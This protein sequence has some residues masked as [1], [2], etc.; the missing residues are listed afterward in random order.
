MSDVSAILFDAQELEDALQ[1]S[2][3][4][5]QNIVSRLVGLGRLEGVLAALN[6]DTY[7]L[8]TR[9]VEQR[10][11]PT[12]EQFISSTHSILV[13]SFAA[14]LPDAIPASKGEL[15]QRLNEC[16]KAVVLARAV[17]S[18][19]AAT[20][21]A[22]TPNRVST[23]H[24]KP[25]S[26]LGCPVPSTPRELATLEAE[27]LRDQGDVLKYFL[28]VLR[29]PAREDVIARQ[30]EL[31]ELE[32]AAAHAPRSST[33]DNAAMA[34]VV[35]SPTALVLT[36]RAVSETG[37]APRP[38][39]IPKAAL[40]VENVE[41]FGEWEVFC[42]DHANKEL[43]KL[44]KESKDVFLM[45]L[46]KIRCRA[47]SQ[48][49]G[50]ANNI[51]KPVEFFPEVREE[52][53]ELDEPTT[54]KDLDD[55]DYETI[56]SMHRQVQFSKALFN[57]FLVGH[58]LQ[59][60]Y[61]PSA[62]EAEII[63]HPSSC[64]IIGRSGTGKTLTMMYKII[65]VERGW[66]TASWY[67]PR[68]RQLFVT[69]SGMLSRQVQRTVG[70]ILESF[71][72]ADMTQQEL[73]DIW[74]RKAE[75]AEHCRPLPRKW[76]EL[77]DDHFP[78]MI[79]F[80]K[81][82]ELLEADFTEA[83]LLKVRT[84]E[85]EDEDL[86]ETSFISA[87]R[88][89]KT[90]WDHLPK[91]A[92]KG[93]DPASV[94]GEIMGVIKGSEGTVN[95]AHGYLDREAYLKLGERS[96]PTFAALRDKVYDIF[97]RYLSL[98][99]RR[100]ERDDADRTHDLLSLLKV[101]GL[102]GKPV[103]FLFN[104]EAQ[105]NLIIDMLLLR[106]LCN[107]PNGLCW[108]GDT[109]Q[110]I[111]LGSSFKFSELTS[112]MYSIE[113][114]NLKPSYW[115]SYAPPR[116]FHL[117]VNYRS[118]AGIINCAQMIVDILTT[119]WSDSIDR[120]DP[121]RGWRKGPKPKFVRRS[122]FRELFQFTNK[123]H[124]NVRSEFSSGQCIIV[125][126]D[127]SRKELFSRGTPGG[128]VMTVY[129]S[130]G[131][132][133]NDV[134]LWHFFESSEPSKRD[135]EC[136]CEEFQ[137]TPLPLHKTT[138]QYRNL[139][140]LYVAITRARNRLWIIEA[141]DSD[142]ADPMLTL[143]TAEDAV[144]VTEASIPVDV[145]VEPDTEGWAAQGR[146]Q[147][148][149][150]NFDQAKY[151]FGR[152]GPGFERESKIAQAYIDREVAITEEEFRAAAS[153]FERCAMSSEGMPDHRELAL[154]AA[155][156][157]TRA[158]A[159]TE[160]A[161]L[162]HSVCEY[163]KCT[164]QYIRATMME[165]ARQVV[166]E[167]K[168]DVD[169]LV[170]KRVCVYFLD[171]S[172]YEPI[173]ELF[174][175]DE[176]SLT[177]FMR[178]HNLLPQLA[179]YFEHLGQFCE[180]AEIH[181]G[182][183]GIPKA[184]E[185]FFRGNKA[186]S[187]ARGT[188]TLLDEL[189]RRYTLGQPVD[190]NFKDFKKLN[191]LL[192]RRKDLLNTYPVLPSDE[193]QTDLLWKIRL[194]WMS[195][196]SNCLHIPFFALGTPLMFPSLEP[197]LALK[198]SEASRVVTTWINTIMYLTSTPDSPS[199]I[200]S[201]V[202]SQ[203]IPCAALLGYMLDILRDCP[204][205]ASMVIPLELWYWYGPSYRRH[206]E[207]LHKYARV[208]ETGRAQMPGALLYLRFLLQVDG[209]PQGREAIIT[210]I[211]EGLA[212]AFV[213][214]KPPVSNRRTLH[215]VILGRRWL[216]TLFDPERWDSSEALPPHDRRHINEFVKLLRPLLQMLCSLRTGPAYLLLPSQLLVSNSISRVINSWVLVARE[217][218]RHEESRLSIMKTVKEIPQHRRPPHLQPFHGESV[219]DDLER[220]VWLSNGPGTTLTPADGLV[221]VQNED[222]Q[223]YPMDTPG[224]IDCVTY[225]GLDSLSSLLSVQPPL[226]AWTRI[227]FPPEWRFPKRRPVLVKRNDWVRSKPV[228]CFRGQPMV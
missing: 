34:P 172:E 140:A 210:Y 70:Q 89:I 57:S 102:P 173:E 179:D 167:H 213:L 214:A 126:D 190:E 134:F 113:K 220:A 97:H 137:G 219:W 174:I 162:Y 104:D 38:A 95:T 53:E 50:S 59:F 166:L 224:T 208:V 204:H 143:W 119:T 76:S 1:H 73:V 5:F 81:L 135:W 33:P 146:V 21:T 82:R 43:R 85:L 158:R 131:L 147:M 10:F 216:R 221:H 128:Q 201:E 39:Y 145:P 41:G 165:R 68:P 28:D 20:S 211:A 35:E 191:G 94:F 29:G 96:H 185:L 222:I 144:E 124:I 40:Y 187:V 121:D 226:R 46:K 36:S 209:H 114:R 75:S 183:H 60:M 19:I 47:R 203:V 163:T 170:V 25:F 192:S 83:G 67:L 61:R 160:S 15:V 110:T 148:D 12:A 159:F 169:E 164:R 117:T 127:A 26:D 72:L 32:A 91:S 180:A 202:R 8:L 63:E 223:D 7:A 11:P 218:E 86:D 215:N 42:T 132:E 2:F 30:R 45:V 22:N 141:E 156:C 37:A 200:S 123:D 153:S 125:R 54:S 31:H 49:R 178:R 207:Q 17:L 77:E 93:F 152:A 6:D 48:P 64:Y 225:K 138:E 80:D 150:Q 155:A 108:A 99:R 188:S 199:S 151:A 112:T 149:K 177:Q 90:Y 58:D 206:I 98:K 92:V 193:S 182:C 74:R 101:H 111:A 181:L 130:K 16:W 197:E 55:K 4:A 24:A 139:K 66:C 44:R 198:F 212:T 133:F 142:K 13:S 176:E 105:D 23:L 27:I 51:F 118:H 79:S 106:S 189:R 14:R 84:G 62:T 186:T 195:S 194:Y 115:H 3:S 129:Q 100:Y 109:A 88:F 175:N 18:E 116:M 136:V 154:S 161:R 217:M 56:L 228:L 107:N 120:L 71:R 157:Y 171:Q 184:I 103:D 227:P 9:E 78:L 52:S 87:G 196:L 205:T 65:S 69:R 168:N 122:G